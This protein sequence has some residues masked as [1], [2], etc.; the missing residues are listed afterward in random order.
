VPLQAG[1]QIVLF[2]GVC[3]LCHGA[4]QFIIKRD[5]QAKFR[6]AAIQ[7]EAGQRLLA[8]HGQ[9]QLGLDSFVLIDPQGCHLRTD[10]ALRIAR[11]LSGDWF[12]FGVFSWLPRRFR[13]WFYD[14]L[15]Q[16][17]YRWFGQRELCLLP[18]QELASR[19]LD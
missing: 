4:V 15:A 1:E 16:R 13:D 9:Q 19:F 12:L 2:D 3:N 11:Q 8:A 6:F 18:S 7:S 5:P 14:R 17:R 10:A